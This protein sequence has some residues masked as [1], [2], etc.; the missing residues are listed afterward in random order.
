MKRIKTSLI[1]AVVIMIL[2]SHLLSCTTVNSSNKASTDYGSSGTSE[3]ESLTMKNGCEITTAINQTDDICYI[4]IMMKDFSEADKNPKNY[5][6]AYF[7]R[8]LDSCNYGY[9]Q[10]ENLKL[11]GP[12]GQPIPIPPPGIKLYNDTMLY[13]RYQDPDKQDD[14]FVFSPALRK[15]RRYAPQQMTDHFLDWGQS[16]YFNFSYKDFFDTIEVLSFQDSL[17]IGG[18]KIY[19]KERKFKELSDKIFEPAYLQKIN[20]Q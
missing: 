18:E 15:I 11:V 8:L 1:N 16:G 2:C 6:I 5:K 19:V 3:E 9:Y 10:S 14:L 17:Y 12:D 13:V 4:H 7:I 20:E